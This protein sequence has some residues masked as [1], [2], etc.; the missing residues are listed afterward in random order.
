MTLIVIKNKQVLNITDLMRS[1][2]KFIYFEPQM[3]S[4]E[5]RLMKMSIVG[6]KQHMDYKHSIGMS[7]VDLQIEEQ[8]QNLGKL[9]MM[10]EEGE[11]ENRKLLFKDRGVDPYKFHQVPGAITEKDLIEGQKIQ[12]EYN[13]R[14]GNALKNLK[15]IA[16]LFFLCVG[17]IG[18]ESNYVYESDAKGYTHCRDTVSGKFVKMNLCDKEHNE[19]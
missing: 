18:C 14:E 10:N 8:L 16:V 6:W 11:F 4:E 17:L 9:L 13:Q 2:I 15:S 7:E 3:S 12:E 5:I 19:N 1:V